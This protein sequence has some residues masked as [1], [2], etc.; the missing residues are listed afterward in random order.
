MAAPSR[1]WRW[2]LGT[3]LDFAFAAVCAL[4]LSAAVAGRRDSPWIELADDWLAFEALAAITLPFLGMA[5][6]RRSGFAFVL[7][8][9]FALAGALAFGV[10]DGG[11]LSFVAAF[12]AFTALR[13]WRWWGRGGVTRRDRDLFYLWI[14]WVP[15]LLVAALAGLLIVK[16]GGLEAQLTTDLHD[17]EAMQ[18]LDWQRYA[19]AA[20]LVYYAM[21]PWIFARLRRVTAPAQAPG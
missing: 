4:A 12:A 3:G 20:G 21:T 2:S 8:L 14:F 6:A 1:S 7:A 17:R 5:A 9:A 13:I 18:V 16:L 10:I 19:L 11:G 15:Q